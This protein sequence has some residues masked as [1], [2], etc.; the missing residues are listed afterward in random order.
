MTGKAPSFLPIPFGGGG[1]EENG[2]KIVAAR[3]TAMVYQL[4]AIG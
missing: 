2:K 1:C 3:C 4:S